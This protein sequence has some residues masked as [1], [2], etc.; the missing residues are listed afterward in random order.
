MPIES[1]VLLGAFP[2][3][4]DCQDRPTLQFSYVDQLR[5]HWR[6]GVI[7][8]LMAAIAIC[9]KKEHYTFTMGSG[10]HVR[11]HILGEYERLGWVRTGHSSFPPYPNISPLEPAFPEK[12]QR[13]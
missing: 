12:T 10:I 9:I 13:A 11:V 3:R 2:E 8:K 6:Q 1:E 5:F 4:A 7:W